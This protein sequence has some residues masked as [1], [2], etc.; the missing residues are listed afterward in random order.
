[1]TKPPVAPLHGPWTVRPYPDRFELWCRVANPMHDLTTERLLAVFPHDGNA[2]SRQEARTAA[3]AVARFP[4][5][6]RSCAEGTNLLERLADA[7]DDVT[8]ELRARTEA[9]RAILDA[10]FT[11]PT[12]TDE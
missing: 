2:L 8:T 12:E 3:Y 9:I 10:T 6:L 11:P 1:M 7:N 5:Y 4:D